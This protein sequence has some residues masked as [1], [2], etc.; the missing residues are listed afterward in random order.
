MQIFDFIVKKKNKSCLLSCLFLQNTEVFS[1]ENCNGQLPPNY[2]P[3][4]RC[5]YSYC[6]YVQYIHCSSSVFFVLCRVDFSQIG[7]SSKSIARDLLFFK[8]ILASAKF[9][10]LGCTLTI[11]LEVI[12][13]KKLYI[14]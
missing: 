1:K 9:Q 7:K 5:F 8:N 13:R 4:K 2:S 14:F 11:R 12:E 6:F 3:Q 10:F